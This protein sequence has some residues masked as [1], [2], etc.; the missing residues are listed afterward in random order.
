MDGFPFRHLEVSISS[1]SVTEA[2]GD[3]ERLVTRTGEVTA[4]FRKL[5][6]SG[7]GAGAWRPR[8]LD[9]ATGLAETLDVE[10]AEF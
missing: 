7:N 2:A 4:R 3:S 9:G 6:G 8:C 10:G 1:S 5:I